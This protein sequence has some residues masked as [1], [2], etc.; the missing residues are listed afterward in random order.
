MKEKKWEMIWNF[1]NVV[2]EEEQ[3]KR[4]NIFNETIIDIAADHYIKEKNKLDQH[5]K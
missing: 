5:P 1:D 2:S 3:V 4:I